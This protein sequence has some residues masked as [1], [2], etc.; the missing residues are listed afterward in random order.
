MG[1]AYKVYNFTGGSGFWYDAGGPD[2]KKSD[3]ETMQ[4]YF[5]YCPKKHCQLWKMDTFLYAHVL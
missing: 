2:M 1:I 3:Y 4:K 5:K